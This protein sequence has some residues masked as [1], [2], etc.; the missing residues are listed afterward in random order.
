[1][2]EVTACIGRAI[3]GS[4]DAHVST[5]GRRNRARENARFQHA[6]Q[7]GLQYQGHLG[8]IVEETFRL[9][10][11]AFVRH[12]CGAMAAATD[13]LVA[14]PQ[15]PNVRVRHVVGSRLPIDPNLDQCRFA[16]SQGPFH[17]RTELLESLAELAC[18]PTERANLPGRMS[19][20]AIP[21][22]SVLLVQA[23]FALT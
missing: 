23:V 21:A 5:K 1:L 7:L 16:S 2:P 6:Q 18:A 9:K 4:D 11:F 15:R 22:P 13:H 19:R 3:G 17:G 20:P 14:V 12:F 8:A 10:L